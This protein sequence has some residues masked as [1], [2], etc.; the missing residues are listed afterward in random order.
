MAKRIIVRRQGNALVPVGPSDVDALQAL[1]TDRELAAEVV[2]PRNVRLHRKAFAL[3]HLAF[4]YWEPKNLVTNVERH[5]V[6]QLGKFLAASGLERDTVRSLCVEFLRH[7]DRRRQ[8]LEAEKSFDAFRE[9][10]TIEAGYF[11]VVLT[12]SGP[13]K[14]AKSWRFASMDDTTFA[15]FYGALFSACWRLVL[16]QHFDSE[17]EAEAAAE[18]LLT[19][20]T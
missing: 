4:S 1:P 19:F 12:P 2:V 10:I 18:Q 9:F 15:A 6:G 5:T 20:D 7:L 17:T 14:V 3:A 16:A 13:R 8:T 11:D